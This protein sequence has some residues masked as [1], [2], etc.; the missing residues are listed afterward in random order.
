MQWN[1]TLR[2]RIKPMLHV[3]STWQQCF[4]SY[5]TTNVYLRHH[6]HHHHIHHYQA[7]LDPYAAPGSR[8][9]GS[10]SSSQSGTV[11]YFSYLVSFFDFLYVMSLSSAMTAMW[12]CC[13]PEILKICTFSKNYQKLQALFL[14]FINPV[15]YIKSSKMYFFFI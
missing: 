15:N 3:R 1:E 12:F 5:D 4:Y 13:E 11:R 14:F 9:S 7:L 6:H 2:W 10:I 8:A